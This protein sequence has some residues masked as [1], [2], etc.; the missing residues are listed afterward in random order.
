MACLH[1]RAPHFFS[2]DLSWTVGDGSGIVIG[3]HNSK[4]LQD[5]DEASVDPS[6]VVVVDVE[7]SGK[8]AAAEE[9]VECVEA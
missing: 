1:S 5:V 2:N 4:D 9:E 3:P 6:V 8:E 7:A